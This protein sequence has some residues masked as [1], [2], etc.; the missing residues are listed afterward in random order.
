ML[1]MSQDG[2]GEENAV[3]GGAGPMALAFRK[4]G[5]DATLTMGLA[6]VSSTGYAVTRTTTQDGIGIIREMYDGDGGISEASLG[7][8][9]ALRSTGFV[10]AGTADSLSVQTSA[11]Y[12]GAQFSYQFGEILRTS[13]LDIADPLFLDNRTRTTF[14]MRSV[15]TRLGVQ[16]EQLLYAH[17]GKG[18]AFERSG[19]LTLGATFSP[20]VSMVSDYERIVETTQGL[21]G[22]NT[23]LDTAYYESFAGQA[24]RV[25]LSWALGAG[26]QFDHV[27]GRQILFLGH[28]EY[29]PWHSASESI[30]D[31]LLDDGIAWNNASRWAMG[32]SLKLGQPEQRQATWGRAT[33][34]MGFTQRTHRIALEEEIDLEKAPLKSWKA[35]AGFSLPMLGSRSMSR[36]EFGIDLG[37][38]TSGREGGLTEDIVGINIGVSLTPFV[39]NLWL[40][41]RLYD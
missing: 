36:F 27:S 23:P 33:Y 2:V 13:M 7:G 17:Y 3:F 8:A 26:L 12:L 39:K 41:P 16:Y 40:T 34:R 32:V 4:Q 25:P 35:S 30:G 5:G 11:L 20:S 37:Q 14:K 28:Y 29:Q 9:W 38:R 21:G 15:G 10:M 31:H 1:R 6:P 24:S 19:A 22:I 18:R